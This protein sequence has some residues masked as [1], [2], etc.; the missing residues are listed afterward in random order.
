MQYIKMTSW[1]IG[2]FHIQPVK[3]N[4]ITLHNYSLIT[5]IRS[6]MFYEGER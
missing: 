5:I 3:N 1:S 2:N 6:Y 4:L